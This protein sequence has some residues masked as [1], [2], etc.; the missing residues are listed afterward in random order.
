[1]SSA[2]YKVGAFAA[3][4]EVMMTRGLVLVTVVGLSASAHADVGVTRQEI[5]G[6]SRAGQSAT[7]VAA[8]RKDGGSRAFCSGTFISRRVVVT[9]AHCMPPFIDGDVQSLFVI[10]GWTERAHRVVDA[11]PHP[12]WSPDTLESDYDVGVL[13]VGEGVGVEYHA[14]LPHRD[15]KGTARWGQIQGYG[16]DSEAH[17]IN[18]VL[19]T[20]CAT[21]DSRSRTTI[22]FGSQSD[23]TCNGDSGGPLFVSVDGA[24]VLA[25]VHVRSDCE[26]WSE[27]LRVDSD[28]FDFLLAHVQAVEPNYGCESD[29]ICDVDRAIFCADGEP[30]DDCA[31]GQCDEDGVCDSQC[32]R[33]PDCSVSNGACSSAAPAAGCSVGATR[34]GAGALWLLLLLCWIAL[35]PRSTA[36]ATL[37]EKVKSRTGAPAERL[38]VA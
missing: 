37:E 27:D 11:V 18:D 5:V 35:R 10:D 28:V 6:G 23:V 13:I 17:A 19:R 16:F 2:S 3:K 12:D 14:R 24:Q 32:T 15:L 38:P 33:D 26:S 1:M 25:G 36:Q 21:I 22:Q 4:P 31:A 20:G 30:D 9:A 8:I 34:S 7:G 29:G